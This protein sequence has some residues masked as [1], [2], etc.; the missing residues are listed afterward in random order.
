MKNL[1]KDEKAQHLQERD[2]LYGYEFRILQAENSEKNIKDKISALLANDIAII[3][4]S[5]LN[6]FMKLWLY[7][8]FILSHLSLPSLINDLDNSFS[9]DLQRSANQK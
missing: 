9:L 7:Q 2:D 5:K 8:F 4:S 6:G 1:R 3:E